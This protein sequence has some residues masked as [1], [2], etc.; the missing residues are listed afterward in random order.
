MTHALNKYMGKVEQGD[1]NA[2]SSD[3]IKILALEAQVAKLVPKGDSGKKR[4][5]DNDDGKPAKKPYKPWV[6]LRRGETYFFEP[7]DQIQIPD[8]SRLFLTIN[9]L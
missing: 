4:R 1:W 3:Q 5:G 7:L 8:L 2:P 6:M 9:I